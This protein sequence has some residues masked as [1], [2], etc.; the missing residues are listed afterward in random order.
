MFSFLIAT[1]IQRAAG[2]VPGE[3]WSFLL[4]GTAGT[5]KRS[6]AYAIVHMHAPDFLTL[7]ATALLNTSIMSL[8]Q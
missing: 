4:R 6:T 3:S 1:A 2:T 8:M 7:M 5:G